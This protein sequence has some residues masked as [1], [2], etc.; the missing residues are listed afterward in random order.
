M[1]D[2]AIV[3]HCPDYGPA[4]KLL[5]CLDDPDASDILY[6]D[7]DWHYDH[8]W[9]ETLCAARG[10]RNGVFAATSFPISRLK[11]H[12]ASGRDQVAQGFGGVLVR[13]DMFGPDVFDLPD[14][15]YAADDIWLSGYL[16][17]RNIPIWQASKARELCTPAITAGDQLQDS[18]ISG[19]NRKAANS[20][21]ADAVSRRFG[22]WPRNVSAL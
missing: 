15:A 17:A 7:D 10:K 20:A 21:C 6:C 14:A 19:L 18:C 12:A 2:G 13:K 4:T 1:P 22:I 5:G 8:I 3:R 16:A 9:A 11:R